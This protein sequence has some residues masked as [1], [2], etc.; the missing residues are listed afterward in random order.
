MFT[1]ILYFITIFFLLTILL[2]YPA[3]IFHFYSYAYFLF[4]FVFLYCALII[5]F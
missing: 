5:F 4:V 2:F 1:F 3:F